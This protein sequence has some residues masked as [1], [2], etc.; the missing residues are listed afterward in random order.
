MKKMNLDSPLCTLEGCYLHMNNL[1]YS[2]HKLSKQCFCILCRIP[3]GRLFL[4]KGARSWRVVGDNI[5]VEQTDPIEDILD[6]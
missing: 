4:L 5:D 3:V 1:L 2:L 6:I